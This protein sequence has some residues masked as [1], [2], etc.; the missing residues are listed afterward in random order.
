MQNLNQNFAEMEMRIGALHIIL[1]ETR[2]LRSK[3]CPGTHSF[4]YQYFPK[5]ASESLGELEKN[6]L[7]GLL[8]RLFSAK[9]R[10][11]K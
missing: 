4:A 9:N 3:F 8:H 6:N 7:A 10:Q 11:R 2:I 5:L 1:D